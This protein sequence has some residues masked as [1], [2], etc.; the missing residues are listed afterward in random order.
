M[1]GDP[2]YVIRRYKAA[3]KAFAPIRPGGGKGRRPSCVWPIRWGEDGTC[4]GLDP[5][6]VHSLL[7][8]HSS[9]LWTIEVSCVM[10]GRI[11]AVVAAHDRALRL[12]PR[13]HQLSG[14]LPMMLTIVGY[15]LTGLNLLFGG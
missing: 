3:V 7:S 9:V 8:Q 6:E 11:V 2:T 10:V 5:A 14:Q 15:T 4:F 13:R 12:L 1:Y